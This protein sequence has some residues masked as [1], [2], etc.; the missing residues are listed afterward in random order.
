VN[1][2]IGFAAA[3]VGMVFGL[4]QYVSAAK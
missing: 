3:G 4:V 2:H 1:W